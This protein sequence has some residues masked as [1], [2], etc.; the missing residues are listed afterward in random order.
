MP[1]LFE[2]PKLEAIDIDEE[3]DW[4]M[5]EALALAKG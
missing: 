1:M 3:E 4:I 5:A 2:T